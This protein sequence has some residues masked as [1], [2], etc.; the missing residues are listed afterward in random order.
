[1]RPYLKGELDIDKLDVNPYLPP[2]QAANAS[3]K[4]AAS[5]AAAP[6]PGAPA[7]GASGGGGAASSGWSD[8]PIDVSALKTADADFAL[9]TGSILYKKITIGKSALALQLKDGKAT[10]DLTRMEL[11]QGTGKSHIVLDGSAAVPAVDLTF[12]LAGV[13]AE[14]VL[15]D[16]MGFDRLSGT[17]QGNFA[18]AGRGKSQ[19][20][21]ISALGGKGS[22]A[23]TN[24]AIKGINLGAIMRDP[25]GTLLDAAQQKEEKTD[26]SSLSGSFVMTNGVAK[27]DD[28][29]LTGPLV[30]ATGSGTVD[31]PKQM[32][33]Y[34]VVPAVGGGTSG[35]VSLP[36]LVRGPF[37]HLSYQ[38]D[39]TALAKDPT[40]AIEG[41][42]G[43]LGS[44][45]SGGAAPSSGTQQ[46]SAPSKPAD[47]LKG[48]F[49]NKP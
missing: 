30:H 7:G 13:Q 3:G 40:K 41:L 6:A 2:E 48:L 4:P 14:P 37:D 44:K 1:V 20:E 10:A 45:P 27:N 25:A 26:F 35:G 39:I 23:F 11:Y 34:R 32:V 17:A 12:D 31:L 46:P 21:L 29:Q 24:G 36:V 43:I 47:V 19:R 42:K 33:D 8:A 18:L 28:L 38:P 9:N 5:P 15:K 49:G 22:L 16:A